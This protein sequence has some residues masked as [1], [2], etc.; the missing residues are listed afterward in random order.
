[1]PTIAVF[2]DIHSNYPAFQ[3]CYADALEQGA[4][5]FVFLGDYVSDLAQPREVLE[6][7]YEIRERYPTYCLR[8]NRER[9]MLDCRAGRAEF[10]PGSKS[11]S[12][13]FTYGQLRERDFR[14]FE[15]LPIH[16]ILTLSGLTF[17]IA[18]ASKEDDRFYFEQD[19]EAIGTVFSRMAYSLLLT[20]HSHRQYA[21]TRNG[22][23]ILNPG[24]VGVP[25]S[26]GIDGEYALLT[27]ENGSLRYRF[28]QVPYDIKAAIHAQFASSLVETSGCWGISILYDILTG[29]E[30]TMALLAE[31]SRRGSVHDE[32]LWRVV[33]EEMGMGFSEEDILEVY[34]QA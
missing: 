14:F 11:G 1:M 23:T 33:A 34:R 22:K 17:E 19:S 20:G 30:K 25:Q 12:L 2:S 7:V 13:L 21:V 31:V 29:E 28:R 4:E 18:H 32:G 24:S 15:S 9:Y 10:S 6:L 27:V 3:A 8:G 16:D 5:G 26:G